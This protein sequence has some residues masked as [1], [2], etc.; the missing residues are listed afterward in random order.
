MSYEKL[1]DS[2]MFEEVFDRLSKEMYYRINFIEILRNRYL[3]NELKKTSLEY[4]AEKH[5]IKNRL[6]LLCDIT[7]KCTTCKKELSKGDFVKYSHGQ[8]IYCDMKGK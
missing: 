6:Y 7:Q 4:K 3:S 8:C 1:I 5:R 2:E